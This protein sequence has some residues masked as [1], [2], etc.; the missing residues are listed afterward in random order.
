MARL[1]ATL[2]LLLA[3][4]GCGPLTLIHDAYLGPISPAGRIHPLVVGEN[5]R[6]GRNGPVASKPRQLLAPL[7]P[8][9]FQ[10]MAST[11]PATR[12]L[13]A[14]VASF[15]FYVDRTELV[16]KAPGY[17]PDRDWSG[18]GQAELLAE[19]GPPQQW[20]QRSE[21]SLLVYSGEVWR[22]HS[23]Y[24]GLPPGVSNLIPIPGISN[25]RFRYAG[26]DAQRERLL[27]FLDA[28]K[29]VQGWAW[30]GQA[31]P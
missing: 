5:F 1:C 2:G 7:P 16:G 26:S 6:V 20:I 29:R 25:L 15:S 4:A 27:F 24:L 22:A 11:I 28:D 3:C 8:R 31:E 10:R 14:A 18:I 23:L 30:G 19:L 17:A 21:G 12:G 13:R 9:L